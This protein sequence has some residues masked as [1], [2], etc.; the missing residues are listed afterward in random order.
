[1]EGVSDLYRSEAGRLRSL[2]LRLVRSAPQ[3][4]D[5][6]QH[7]FANLLANGR[8]AALT[9]QYLRVAVRNLALNHLRDRARRR[10]TALDAAIAGRLAAPEPT[11]EI[12]LLYRQELMRVL[13]AIMALPPR[14]REAFV[15]ARIRALPLAE[16][17]AR[18]RISRNTAISHVVAACVEL[19]A[20]LQ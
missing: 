19:E 3:A 9:P 4:E 11:A 10:E 16:V 1:M 17:A 6:V 15:L 20:R 14:R 7:A 12:V 8:D 13:R 18:M 2:A 5:L